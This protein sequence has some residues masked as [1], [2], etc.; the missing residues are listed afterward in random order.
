MLRCCSVG[1]TL[2]GFRGGILQ[3]C[4]SDFW[5]AAA[6]QMALVFPVLGKLKLDSLAAMGRHCLCQG[7]D[8]LLGWCSQETKEERNPRRSPQGTHGKESISLFVSS[9]TISRYL[10]RKE[11]AGARVKMFCC[12]VACRNHGNGDAHKKQ[13][14][15]KSDPS[16]S[17]TLKG[18]V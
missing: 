17:S 4:K 9:F 12:C 10:L 15:G 16:S 14:R 6:G 11:T 5:G 3:G 13:R 1:M 7:K 8:V 2:S 18:C